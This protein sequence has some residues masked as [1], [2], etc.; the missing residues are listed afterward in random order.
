M[1]KLVLTFAI[2][3]LMFSSCKK[4]S[5]KKVENML[6]DGTWKITLFQEDSEDYTID[7]AGDVFT[8]K[9]D[10]TVSATHS[11][12]SFNGTWSTEKDDDHT[13]LNLTFSNP[14]ELLE[15]SDDWDVIEK[16]DR[17]LKLLDESG[18]GSIDLLTFEKI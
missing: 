16:T 5:P 12:T 1:K 14:S 13:E 15:L 4:D 18:D 8:F 17:I 11:A 9:K 7:Y 10:G 2:I 3:S 6:E